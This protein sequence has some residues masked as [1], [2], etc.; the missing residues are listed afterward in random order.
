MAHQWLKTLGKHHWLGLGLWETLNFEGKLK[1]NGKRS[2]VLKYEIQSIARNKLKCPFRVDQRTPVIKNDIV[3]VQL[4]WE[5]F[6][7]P[8][9]KLTPGITSGLC[10]HLLSFSSVAP[11]E[12]LHRG[13]QIRK[14]ASHL[15]GTVAR[16]ARRGSNYASPCAWLPWCLGFTWVRKQDRFMRQ[17]FELPGWQHMVLFSQDLGQRNKQGSATSSSKRL[18]AVSLQS[19]ALLTISI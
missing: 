8:H 17:R 12:G 1:E 9:K 11:A 16:Y 15:Q 6:C 19:P 14:P 5:L 7:M 13:S 4:Q 3:H 10:W 2:P 18:T